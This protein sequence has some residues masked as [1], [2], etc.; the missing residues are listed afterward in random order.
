[1]ADIKLP[2]SLDAY[3]SCSARGFINGGSGIDGKSNCPLHFR[4]I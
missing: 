1:M 4:S 2:F 3:L